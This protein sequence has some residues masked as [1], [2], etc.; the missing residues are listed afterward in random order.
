MILYALGRIFPKFEF[1]WMID[2]VKS[3]LERELNFKLEGENADECYAALSPHLKFVYVPKVFWEYTTKRVLVMEYIDGI[4]ISDTEKLKEANLSLQEI[5]RKLVE[6]TAF[7]IFH[8]GFVH[9]DPHVCLISFYSI[10]RKK[11]VLMNIFS[12]EM[13]ILEK[14]LK[15]QRNQMFKLFYLI[16]VYM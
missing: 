8:T 12:L 16:M 11:N 15:H 1:S 6:A 13:F 10:N 14:I 3:N 5:D 4:K 2:S 9:A 7:Q